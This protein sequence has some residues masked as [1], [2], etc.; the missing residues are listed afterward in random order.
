MQLSHILLFATAAAAQHTLLDSGTPEDRPSSWG[1]P[2]TKQIPSAVRFRSSGL[3]GEAQTID[4]VDFMVN[5]DLADIKA[6][7]TWIGVEICPS[8]EDVPACPPTSVAE[9]IP[10]EVRG[11]RTTLHWVPAT[12]KV[13]EPE[14]LYWFIVSSNVENALQAVSWYPGSKRYGTD[15]DP[16]SDVASATRML[17]P[18]GGMDWVVEPS[19]GVAP[20]DHRRVPNAKI[21][22][23]A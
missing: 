22:V 5:T 23:K 20:L 8:V 17:V 6:N 9:Q 7:A 14:S 18:W 12:P 4:Y 1:S 21:V 3:C 11:K 2:V 10:I 15:N 13:L 19:G 16:K